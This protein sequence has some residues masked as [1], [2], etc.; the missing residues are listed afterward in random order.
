MSFLLTWSTVIDF[1]TKLAPKLRRLEYFLSKKFRMFYIWIQILN[2]SMSYV[3]EG[4]SEKSQACAVPSP[5]CLQPV[6]THS[7]PV[8]QTVNAISPPCPC[9]NPKMERSEMPRVKLGTQ[10]LEV[11][12]CKPYRSW[13]SRFGLE[14]FDSGRRNLQFR[15]HMKILVWPPHL[16]TNLEKGN[17]ERCDLARETETKDAIS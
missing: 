5:C 11:T 1:F 8:R 17:E 3:L 4:V 16:I 9:A 7:T 15:F 2:S 14:S 10:G 6:W 13:D 12:D